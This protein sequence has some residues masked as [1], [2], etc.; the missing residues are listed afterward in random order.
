MIKRINMLI[1]HLARC[2]SASEYGFSAQIVLITTGVVLLITST[3]AT[4]LISEL[5]SFNRYSK[6]S[7]AYSIAK[8][9]IA[10]GLANLNK[11][12]F[13][14]GNLT[15]STGKGIYTVSFNLSSRTLSSTGTVKTIY[16]TKSEI[17][18]LSK[19]ITVKLVEDPQTYKLEESFSTTDRRDPAVSDADSVVWK[20][21]EGLLSLRRVMSPDPWRVFKDVSDSGSIRDMIVFNSNLYVGVEGGAGGGTSGNIYSIDSAGKED[22][23]YDPAGPY[24]I[25]RDFEIYNDRIWAAIDGTF[26]G[27]IFSSPDGLA[28]TLDFGPISAVS[29]HGIT[30]PTNVNILGVYRGELYAGVGWGIGCGNGQ[31]FRRNADG[32]WAVVGRWEEDGG[33]CSPQEFEPF[34]L[35]EYKGRLY[36]A[37]SNRNSGLLKIKAYDGTTFTDVF[38]GGAGTFRTAEIINDVLYFGGT[39]G[40][41]VGFDGTTW[42]TGLTNAPIWPLTT[43]QTIMDLIS[44]EGKMYAAIGGGRQGNVQSFD[45][46]T[47]TWERIYLLPNTSGFGIYS[48]EVFNDKLLA[49]DGGSGDNGTRIIYTPN[50]RYEKRTA[51]GI[52]DTSDGNIREITIN[53]FPAEGS[54]GLLDDIRVS[55]KGGTW[56][57]NA[58]TPEIEDKPVSRTF[59][60]PPNSNANNL[61]YRID[62]QTASGVNTPLIDHLNIEY[63]TGDKYKIDYS[64]WRTD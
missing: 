6:T 42:N 35:K 23:A 38:S 47:N 55:A 53:I 31:L 48:L 1:R 37:G 26:V 2:G 62:M 54:D 7:D 36:L 39:G 22:L 32:A 15:G 25:F 4:L 51:A 63:I 3:M 50:M 64:T 20:T 61:R 57:T 58:T 16:K 13:P 43:A 29:T 30:G 10:V 52:F 28:W 41:I 9:G 40:R 12:T 34:V 24:Y 5:R 19:T 11:N 18:T 14:A 44:Y 27:G 17:N 46:N 21:G 8:E 56:Q 59:S 60:A 45:V 49:A 33:G